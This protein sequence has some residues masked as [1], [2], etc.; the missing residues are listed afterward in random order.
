[1]SEYRKYKNYKEQIPIVAE[2]IRALRKERGYR[3]QKDFAIALYNAESDQEISRAKDKVRERDS[4]RVGYTIN[5]LTRICNLFD[6]DI[7]Y[8]LCRQDEETRDIKDL[9]T[10]TGL[11]E[12]ACKILADYTRRKTEIEELEDYSQGKK[13]KNSYSLAK[14]ISWLIE[15]GTLQILSDLSVVTDGYWYMFNNETPPEYDFVNPNN[16][17]NQLVVQIERNQRELIKII[18]DYC[19]QKR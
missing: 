13:P 9:K 1:M 7:D 10:I 16:P 11:S 15:N 8:L 5:E 12:Q 3:T 6:V 4:H 14:A 18:E 2:R 19:S 17:D